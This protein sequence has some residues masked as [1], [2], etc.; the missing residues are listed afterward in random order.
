VRR[1]RHTYAAI[2]DRK[3]F[4]VC[5]PSSDQAVI[6]DFCGM[7]SGRNTDKLER[8]SLTAKRGQFVDAPVVAEFPVCLECRMIHRLEIG[9]HDL[10]VGE[11][12]AS[13]V[14]EKYLDGTGAADLLSMSPIAYGPS[15]GGGQYFTL[16]PSAGK[17]FEIGKSLI[18]AVKPR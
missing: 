2:I 16:G 9:S 18:D 4:T 10:F 15:T 11:V 6:A 1:E 12:L 13:W 8:A 7:A 5:L 14:D 3:A 17:S